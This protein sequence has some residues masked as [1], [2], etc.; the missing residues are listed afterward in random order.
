MAGLTLD[1]YTDSDRECVAIIGDASE[2]AKK[3]RLP[4]SEIRA[5]LQTIP[6]LN[7]VD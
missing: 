6:G 1:I 5:L 3:S 4:L 7:I 2:L